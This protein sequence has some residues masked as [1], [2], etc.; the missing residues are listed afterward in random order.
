M[1][2]RISRHAPEWLRD[3]EEYIEIWKFYELVDDAENQIIHNTNQFFLETADE[4]GVTRWEDAF[5]LPHTGTLDERTQNVLLLLQAKIPYTFR[6]L[7]DYLKIVWDDPKPHVVVHLNGDY[8]ITLQPKKEIDVELFLDIM[9][10]K[11]PANLEIE[12]LPAPFVIDDTWLGEGILDSAGVRF[13]SSGI[14]DEQIVQPV[15]LGQGVYES[16]GTKY[17]SNKDE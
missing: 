7:K 2:N 17:V 4:E 3:L 11:I 13:L 16:E 15:I 8:I 12:L 6:W 1:L 5:N 9:R 14:Y 10:K